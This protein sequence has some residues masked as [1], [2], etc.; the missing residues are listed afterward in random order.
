MEVK[1][2]KKSIDIIIFSEVSSEKNY[3]NKLKSPMWPGGSSGVTI[4]LGY[5]L[6]QTDLKSFTTVWKN[7][8]NANDFNSLSKAVGVKGTSAQKMISS[9]KNIIV[10]YESAC[11]A[12]Y[13]HDLPKYMKMTMKAFPGIEKMKPD[14]VGAVLSLVYNRGGSTTGTNR[15]E[16]HAMID[17]IK[18]QDYKA[19]GDLVEKM[20]R[21]WA[22][23]PNLSGLVIRRKNE[24][25]LIR[26][27]QHEYNEKDLITI[28]L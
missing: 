12:F 10:S 11:E 15:E 16:M 8:L 18:K 23:K 14:A 3:N 7:K 9:L 25:D 20:K 22:N 2:S 13:E 1:V 5:D 26:S 17:T 27:A 6:G 24:A 28:T 21:I 19:T 4:G